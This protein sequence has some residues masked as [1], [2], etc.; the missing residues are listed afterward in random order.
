MKLNFRKYG[1][2][3]ALIILHGLYGASDNWVSIARELA[4]HFEVYVPDQRNHG[5]SPHTDNHNYELLK[6]DLNGFMKQQSIEKATLLGHSM[7]GKVAMFFAVDHPEKVENLIVV[8]I[9]PRSYK[10]PEQPVPHKVDHENLIE[11]LQEVDFSRAENRMDIDMMLAQSVKSQRI[12]QFLLK[13]V[14]R[15]DQESFCWK[16]NLETLK[17]SLPHIMDGLNAEKVNNGKGIKGFPV[18]FIRGENSDYISDPDFPVIKKIFP[19]AEIVTI[20]NSGHWLHA[21]QPELLLKN[22]RYFLAV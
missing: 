22:L 20:P 8:D 16:L 21:E 2:G 11:A 17:K 15:K 7:G 9:S 14:K 18:L 6:D 1:E 12:R 19:V 3:P 4:D 13:N 5:A 10:D